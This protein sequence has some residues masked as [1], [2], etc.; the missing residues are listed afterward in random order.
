[1]HPE[2][3]KVPFAVGSVFGLRRWN[4]VV[5]RKWP[6][7]GFNYGAHAWEPGVTEAVCASP[8]IG[9]VKRPHRAGTTECTCG[10]YAAWDSPEDAEFWPALEISPNHGLGIWGVVEGFGRIAVGPRGF[11]SEKARIVALADAPEMAEIYGC[12]SYPTMTEMLEAHPLST[13]DSVRQLAKA[14]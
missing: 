9:V 7:V 12:P 2:Y 14:S 3:G 13:W 10:L 4:E 5:D 6:L 8:N 11:R 1:V